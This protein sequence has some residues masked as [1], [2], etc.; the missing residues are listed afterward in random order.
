L[1]KSIKTK[2]FNLRVNV[3]LGNEPDPYDTYD[4]LFEIHKKYNIEPIYFFLLADYAKND[5]SI[6][7]K[8]KAFQALIKSIS[9]YHTVGIHPSYSS[10]YNNYSLSKE[11]KRLKDITH[12]DINKSRQHFLKL[13]LPETY[14][15]L[16]ANDIEEDY[17]MG[18][19]EEMGF[20]ASICSPYYFYDLDTETESQLKIIP[21]SVMEASFQYYQELGIVETI[22]RINK[23]MDIVKNV[24]GTFVS[25]W[26]NESLS[27]QGIWK[28]WQ[29]VYES[30]L[31][32]A[33]N[34]KEKI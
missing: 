20:R 33:K 15:R 19:A 4:Y 8:N 1:F 9:D 25:V 5:K 29:D 6:S 24:K 23:I 22:Q 11:I 12:K 26:H 10:N 13:N 34:I 27:N 21:F 7:I 17:T 18:Y 2:D 16:I 3:L 14:R 31:Q 32:E 30:M 28:G